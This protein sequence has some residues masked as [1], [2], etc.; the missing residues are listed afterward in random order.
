VL[1]H[2]PKMHGTKKQNFVTFDD[3]VEV[4]EALAQLI[5]HRRK[6]TIRYYGAAHPFIH[7]LYGLKAGKHPRIH[8]MPKHLLRLGRRRW[9]RTLWLVY[10]IDALRCKRC[11]RQLR[12]LAVI[13]NPDVVARILMYLGQRGTTYRAVRR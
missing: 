3:P 6:H 7:K 10:G 2:A 12:Q 4:L 13:T 9:A 8:K 5:P 1:Y 11:K